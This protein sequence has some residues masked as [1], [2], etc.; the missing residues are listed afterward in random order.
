MNGESLG[1]GLCSCRH[2]YHLLVDYLHRML[3]TRS[4]LEW[5]LN[6]NQLHVH[7][8]SDMC[9]SSLHNLELKILC[10]Y[11]VMECGPEDHAYQ[12]QSSAS[13]VYPTMASYTTGVSIPLRTTSHSTDLNLIPLNAPFS[14]I[15]DFSNLTALSSSSVGRVVE[16]L[17]VGSPW[18]LARERLYWGGV[19][20][21]GLELGYMGWG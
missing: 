21:Y 13:S 8:E 11:V 10:R 7:I 18:V 6:W 3:P 19:G 20:R 15:C 4:S 17:L 16:P 5:V 1:M 12:L 14:F 2:T 9:F